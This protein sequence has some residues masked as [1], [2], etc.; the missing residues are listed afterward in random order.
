MGESVTMTRVKTRI[1]W[2]VIFATV[3]F[4]SGCG[5]KFFDPTQIGRF[6]P[7]PVVNVILDSLQFAK[8]TSSTWEYAE[9]PRL[10][11]IIV[12]ESDYIAD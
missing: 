5:N 2:A 4:I 3:I 12:D 6:R 7:T 11:D 8:E 9:E 10:S 1:Y